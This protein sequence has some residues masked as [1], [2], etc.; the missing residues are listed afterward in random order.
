MKVRFRPQ[1]AEANRGG[2]S[3]NGTAVAIKDKSVI[4][5]VNPSSNSFLQKAKRSTRQLNFESQT[6]VKSN[7]YQMEMFHSQTPPPPPGGGEVGFSQKLF[8]CFFLN[9]LPP[10]MEI[11]PPQTPPPPPGCSMSVSTETY[12]S[13]IY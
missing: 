2:R 1:I 11:F 8:P 4:L 13:V 9:P 3:Y 10:Q 6:V 5:R 12:Y 7:W